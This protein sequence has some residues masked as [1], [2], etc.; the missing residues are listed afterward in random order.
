MN[1]EISNQQQPKG[2]IIVNTGDGKGKTTA[3]LGVIFR[4]WGYGLRICMIQFIKSSVF[5]TGEFKA[6]RQLNIEWHRCGDGFVFHQ[7]DQDEAAALA[8]EGWKLAQQKILSA[9]Y[10]LIVLDECTYPLIFG[11]LD[12]QEVADWILHNKPAAMHL[13]ITGR[14]APQ[15]LIDI[16]DLVTEMKLIKHPFQNGIKAQAGTEF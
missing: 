15:K 1:S 12:P 2:L 5:E 16:A 11:W 6:A 10:D 8:L 14:N 7:E 3:A 4:S 9:A 13:I